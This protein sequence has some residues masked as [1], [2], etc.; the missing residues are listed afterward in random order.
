MSTHNIVVLGGSF[1]GLSVAHNL[2]R[3]V[4][5]QLPDSSN[6]KLILVNPS[7][8]FYFKLAAPRM[9]PREDLIHFDQIMKPFKDE[10]SKYP[11]FEFIQAYARNLDPATRQVV[12]ERVYGKKDSSCLYYDTL[13]I[14]TGA[15]SKSP[16]W[17]PAAPK[18]ETEAALGEFREKL[19][20]AQRVIVAGGGAVGVETTGELGFDHGKKKDILIYSGTNSLLGRVRPDVGK[21][22]EKYLQQMGVTVIHNIKIISSG[23]DKD[24]KEVLYLSDGS[25]TT[26]DLF[27]D[28]RGSKL[29]ND[30]LPSSWLNERGAVVVDEHQRVKA[31]GFGSRIYAVGDIASTSRGSVMD[32]Q[33]AIPPLIAVIE[34]D[35]SNGKSGAQSTW[36]GQTSQT[37][38]VPVGRKKAVGVMFDH[39]V[40]S[41]VVSMIKGKTFFAQQAPDYVT[42]EKWA[43]KKV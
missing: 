4:I 41:F 25:Q 39:W 26:A 17:S 19:K 20:S 33:F 5:P 13:I 21:R 10:L 29:N 28:A 1:A 24:G 37:M 11:Q 32:V 27:I 3:N 43:K 15:S 23:S 30:Y 18:E 35:L 14:A 9:V 16:L 2:L 31:A 36:T 22:A 8:H 42:G 6:Y 40:P 34:Y 38:L 12:I 7:D